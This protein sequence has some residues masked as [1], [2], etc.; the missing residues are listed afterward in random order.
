MGSQYTESECLS[1]LRSAA[2]KLGE[3]PTRRGYDAIGMRPSAA[4]ISN[5]FGTWNEA[6]RAAGLEV[7]RGGRSAK[8]VR[9]DYFEE[10]D[11]S[12]KAYW[13][14]FLFG[15][16]TLRVR[17]AET[18]R[19]SVR[20]CLH[21]KDSG[22]LERY[23]KVIRCKSATIEDGGM[24]CVDVGNQTFAEHLF[25]KGFTS[26]KGT[27]GSL[28]TLETWPLK[29]GF[30]RGLAD[31]DGYYGPNKWTI[32]DANTKRL[33]RLRAWIPVEFDVV[34]EQHDGRKWA[35]LRVS[36]THRLRALYSWLFPRGEATEPAMPRKKAIAMAVLRDSA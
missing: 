30:V 24:R 13:L 12:A 25:E 14:G 10:I 7:N 19:Y 6:K 33:E 4:A 1:A 31:A 20:L 11:S 2:Q 27:D 21:E 32:T 36:R 15:D 8:P 34:E 23:K 17:N 5:Q 35:Y 22:H 18:K 28:P 16:G 3:S 29:R 26:S 9:K